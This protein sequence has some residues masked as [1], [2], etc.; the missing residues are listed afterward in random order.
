MV[1][2]IYGKKVGSTQVFSN[3][4]AA[5][6]VTAI[7]ASP[8]TVLQVK[9]EASDGYKS[10]KV[11]FG[12]VKEKKVNKP[13][14]GVFTK[15]NLAAKKY[16]KELR[17]EDFDHEYKPGDTIDVQVFKV[18]DKVKITGISRGKGFTGV[19]KRYNFHRGPMTHGSHSIRK[20]GSIGMCA[21]PSKVHKGKKMPGRMGGKKV[22]IP[23]TEIIDIIGEQ[24]LI[25]VKGSVPGPS[26]NIVL[27]RKA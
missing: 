20:P 17:V 12:N 19:I 1:N 26:G 2:S 3:D 16:I 25:L 22:T 6:Y 24:N 4:G 14:K 9:D 5:I 27:L 7:E 11:G 8:C 13:I 23:A 15:N 18:G 10:L 21:T